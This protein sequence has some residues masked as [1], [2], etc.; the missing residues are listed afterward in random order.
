MDGGR[1][2]HSS[3]TTFSKASHPRL[4]EVWP[5]EVSQY[6]LVVNPRGHLIACGQRGDAKPPRKL[7]P[8][9]SISVFV[10]LEGSLRTPPS[11]V[12]PMPV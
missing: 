12:G 11:R 2:I 3:L 6:R 10:S 1:S 5:S 9:R 4:C 8:P 7:L